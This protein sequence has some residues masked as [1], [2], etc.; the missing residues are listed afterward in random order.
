MLILKKKKT[1]YRKDMPIYLFDWQVV[2]QQ[3]QQQKYV[4][5]LKQVT[6]IVMNKSAVLFSHTARRND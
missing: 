2:Q 5:R 4:K 3:Q 1:E 6:F